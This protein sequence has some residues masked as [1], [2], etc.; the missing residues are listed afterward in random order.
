M[1]FAKPGLGEE[2]ID[3]DGLLQVQAANDTADPQELTAEEAMI[4]A[5]AYFN[6]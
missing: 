3:M 6:I 1:E 4:K 2:G 5:Q